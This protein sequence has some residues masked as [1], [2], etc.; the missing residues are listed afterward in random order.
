MNDLTIAAAQVGQPWTVP[1]SDGVEAARRGSVPHLLATH[2]V[3]HAMKSLGKLAAVFEALDH[4]GAPAPDAAQLQTVKD[5][6]ADLLT[7]ALRLA[8]LY[9][10]SLADELERR[11][12][13]KNG[14]PVRPRPAP[15]KVTP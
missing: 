9:S 14:V 15:G 3:L 11:V 7:A 4:S 5:M 6:A 13:E 12:L 2:D 1:Y 10:F 8:N